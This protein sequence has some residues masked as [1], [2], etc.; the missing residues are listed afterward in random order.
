MNAYTLPTPGPTSSSL[1][2]PTLLSAACSVLPNEPHPVTDPA[3]LCAEDTLQARQLYQSALKQGPSSSADVFAKNSCSSVKFIVDI[4]TP[5]RKQQQQ[6][7]PQLQH[8]E[9]RTQPQQPSGSGRTTASPVV[10]A[11]RT[12][13]VGGQGDGS[14]TKRQKVSTMADSVAAAADAG[15]QVL[16]DQ[17]MQEA[18]IADAAVA[19]APAA[20]VQDA[21]GVQQS[22]AAPSAGPAAGGSGRGSAAGARA[23]SGRQPAGGRAGSRAAKGKGGGQKNITSFFGK[24]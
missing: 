12:A 16:E 4:A 5:P 10:A 9:D 18:D 1:H 15:G 6:Q 13:A 17:E 24:Q 3:R 20:V 7:G 19:V 11:G 14:A 22:R 23:G 2:P 21:E 8:Q